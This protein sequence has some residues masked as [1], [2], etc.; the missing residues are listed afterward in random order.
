M[1]FIRLSSLIKDYNEVFSSLIYTRNIVVL[2]V[3]LLLA[4]LV[5]PSAQA[6]EAEAVLETD[7]VHLDLNIMATYDN[8]KPVGTRQ[9]RF[10][11]LWSLPK[12]LL[13]ARGAINDTYSYEFG[14]QVYIKNLTMSLMIGLTQTNLLLSYDIYG[15]VEPSL[16][17]GGSS[18]KVDCRWRYLTIDKKYS[19]GGEIWVN[20]SQTLFLNFSCFR[21]GLNT[22]KKARVGTRTIIFQN[23][24]SFDIPYQ[25]GSKVYKVTLDPSMQIDTPSN[26]Y[27][28]SQTENHI[29]FSLAILP[30][31]YI[32]TSILLAVLVIIALVNPKV[33]EWWKRQ[34]PEQKKT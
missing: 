33:R 24:S 10:S 28:V 23:V 19:V 11:S 14:D 3:C 25:I 6:L 29:S 8:Q 15:V 22:W 2:I 7:H 21:T 31:A 5:V 4:T 26:A 27:D 17:L 12:I 20:L 16:T 32:V 18:F 34:I 13:M 1:L 9:L 30:L